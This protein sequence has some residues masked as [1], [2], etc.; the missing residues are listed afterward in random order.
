[1]PSPFPGMDPWL[2]HPALWPD[3]HRNLISV[4]QE[5]LTPLVAPDYYVRGEE[6]VYIAG[7]PTFIEPD[8]LVVT[9]EARAKY[10]PANPAAVQTRPMPSG[11]VVF[12]LT[13][14]DDE[15]RER[16]LEIRERSTSRVVTVI[17][18][19]SPTN[20]I[21]GTVRHQQFIRKRTEILNSDTHWIE[22]D[23]LRAGTRWE[24]APGPSDYCVILSRV[25][26]RQAE[27]P[28]AEAWLFNLPDPL[29]TVSIPL[30]APHP[31]V[32]LDLQQALNTVYDRAGYAL[33]VDYTQPLELPL[34]PEMLAWAKAAVG[35]K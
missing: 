28:T 15:V 19:L 5:L 30:H 8:V 2:E 1:M 24:L 10:A 16:Y 17:E 23:L 34:P 6:R 32:A 29:P 21:K 27:N 7:S 22:I 11:A 12:P 9:R 33:S 13:Y 35:S 3:V 18:I 14:I 31:D 25:E 20:K 26:R 4:C